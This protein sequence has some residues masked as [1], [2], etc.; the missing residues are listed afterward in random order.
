MRIENIV[1]GNLI[2]A[3]DYTR[4]V[5]TF[6]KSEY[7]GDIAD[8]TIFELISSYILKYNNIPTKEALCIDLNERTGLSDEQFKSVT[9]AIG[10]LK[11]SE[12][13]EI[14][15]LIDTTE[16]FCRDKALYNALIEAIK[17]VDTNKDNLS[18]GS[19]PKIMSD[20]LAV[21]FDNSVGHDFMDDH[22][23]R[24]EFYHRNEVKIPFDLEYFNAI[25]RGGLSRKTLNIGLAGTGVGKSLFMCHCAAHN[26][27]SGYNVLYITLEMA[28]EKIAE[29]IDANTMNLTI[30]ELKE[31][32][33][34]SYD[35][36]FFKLKEQ[37]KGRLIIKEYPTACAGSANFRHLINEL[38]IKKNFT[39][40][41]IYIDYL[42]ICASSRIKPGSNINSY[43]YIKAIAEE[44]RGLAVEFNVPI[45]SATQTTRS[46]FSSSDV[47]LTDTAE[48]FGL[49]ATADFMFALIS[50]EELEGLGQMMVKQL[51]NR[52][53]DPSFHKR[54]VIGVDRSRMKLFDAEASA[55]ED[56]MDSGSVMDKTSFG[57]RYDDDYKP[58]TKFDKAKFKGFTV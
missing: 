27:K 30:D 57:K 50:T 42:N 49:P 55:Q 20:A 54:F 47:E 32:P 13:K 26:L 34:S 22:E 39:P 14:D 40:D 11:P 9:E 33:K 24:F 38:K 2:H 17:I 29:R 41:I 18:V 15:W 23:A 6:L 21:S 3:E 58:A 5:I 46:G 56:L 4:K 51:K 36:K 25:T 45:V 28:E 1:L 53:G 37:V 31:I 35:K 10:G 12:G 8:K 44:L 52:Y 43:T 16:K 7:F 48:S 19:I